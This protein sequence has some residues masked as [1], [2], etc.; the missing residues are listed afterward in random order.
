MLP[1][2]EADLTAGVP[3]QGSVRGADA[4]LV[5]KMI[6]RGVRQPGILQIYKHAELSVVP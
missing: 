2:H 4:K 5:E 3:G 1:V 6:L